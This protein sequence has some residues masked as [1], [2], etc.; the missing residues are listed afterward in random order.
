MLLS[1]DHA[2]TLPGIDDLIDGLAE[3]WEE[4]T[5]DEKVCIAILDGPVDLT[6]PSLAGADFT[7]IDTLASGAAASGPV[8]E[9]G[10][11]VASVIFGQH[12]GPVKG[13]APKCRGLIAPIFTD[14]VDGVPLP[15]SQI[16]LARALLQVLQA[17]AKIINISGGQFSPSGTAHPVLT[18][19]V[20]T[21]VQNGALIVAAAGNQGC[22]CLHIPG[23]LPSVLA[24][25]A[26]N[27][28]GD[29]LP[30]SNWGS[31]YQAQGILAPGE[32][33]LVA[34]P[35]GRT[36]TGSGTS[37]ATPIVTGVAALL[38]SLQLKRGQRPDA[39]A[40]REALLRSALGCDFQPTAE[41][42]RLLAG[43]LDV[44]GA[45][46][47]INL[48]ERIMTSTTTQTESM[49][50]IA[51]TEN[52]KANDHVRPGSIPVSAA[53]VELIERAS[54]P[55]PTTT[56]RSEQLRADMG[57]IAPSACGCGGGASSPQLA[58]VLGQLGYDLGTEARR[59]SFIQNMNE[60]APETR[61]NPYDPKQL[62]NY[63]QDNPFGAASLIW[64][65]NLDATVIYAVMPSGPYA[66]EAY[67]RLRQFLQEQL[68]EGVERISIPG[69]VAGKVR[70]INGQVVPA[71][72]PEIRGMCSW[73]TGA[74][75]QAVIGAPLP[76]SATESDKHE[77]TVRE[78]SVREFLDRIYFE[79]RNLGTTPQDRAV[80]YAGTNAFNI[81]KAFE[82][83][84]KEDMNLDSIEVGRSP[85]CRPDSDC[86]DVKLLFFFP[87]RQVQTVRKAYRFTVDVSDVVPVT[88]GPVRSWFVR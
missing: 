42:E 2:E 79:L 13:I 16:D 39:A 65:L 77:R 75:V 4:T 84:A 41:C 14:V 83:A 73:T 19:A 49:P 27:A 6:H 31:A 12:V 58:Y 52:P 62:L 50:S 88:V 11:Q 18:D 36:D 10:T 54:P 43:R 34:V 46:S 60:P 63:L 64:T 40:V 7:E 47:I 32:N 61:G 80:N 8:A 44:N 26:M 3:L 76:D 45:V 29:P 30:F 33:I 24:V 68:T 86:W 15:C 35:G 1:E 81:D 57:M 21:C 22:D 20:R 67:Q 72:I 48:G 66:S 82:S 78:N 85:I 69:I 38:L 23:S 28:Q 37:F 87:N 71:I 17:G 59:D 74:L 9:H 70:L 5:G 55:T 51:P 53:Q 56:S 25:G